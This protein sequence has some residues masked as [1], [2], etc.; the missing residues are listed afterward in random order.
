MLGS[1]LRQSSEDA[2]P[3]H[4]PVGVNVKPRMRH[5]ARIQQF[6]F[7]DVSRVRLQLRPRQYFLPGEC[8]QSVRIDEAARRRTYFER[9][10]FWKI[11]FEMGRVDLDARDFSRRAEAND[12][13]IVPGPAATAG[14]PAVMHSGRTA[15]EDQVVARTKKHIA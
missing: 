8:A 7:E 15:G 2:Q 6:L 9:T 12:A 5:F 1:P 13:P 14:F 10:A 3:G 11:A 4:A